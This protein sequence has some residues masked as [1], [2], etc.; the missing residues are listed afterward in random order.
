MNT[1]DLSRE[2]RMGD[3]QA[4]ENQRDETNPP[5]SL[6]ADGAPPLDLK[7]FMLDS[8]AGNDA[9]EAEREADDA[10]DEEGRT[11]LSLTKSMNY[12]VDRAV[13]LLADD[14]AVFQKHSQLVK[15]APEEG[16]RVLLRPFKTSQLRYILAKRAL[17]VNEKG[18]EVHPPTHIAKCILER[19]AWERIRRLRAVTDFPA[20]APDGALRLEP[21][22][23]ETT[24]TFFAGNVDVRVPEEPTRDDAR[25]AVDQLYDIVH[26]FPFAS[27]E[28]R[29][30]W[31][32]GLLTPLARY[33]H[34]GNAPL[35]VVQANGPRIGKTTLVKLISYVVTGQESAAMTHTTNEEEARKRILSLL[36]A[37]RTLVLVDNIV[38]QF[39]GATVNAVMTSRTFEDRLLGHSVVIR[40]TNDTTW[41]VTGNNMSLAPDTAERC[42][43]VRLQSDLEKPH[44]RTDF[45]HERLFDVVKERRGQLLSAALTIL[46]A[47]LVAGMPDQALSSWGGFESWS[48]V[49][50]GALVYAGASD[51]AATRLELEEHADEA[52]DERA[53]LVLGI[54]EWQIAAGR[55]AGW[56]ASELLEHV[57][58]HPEGAL[59]L[60]QAL[61]DI[62]GDRGALP[63]AKTLSRHLRESW[64]RNVRNIVLHREADRKNG[65]RWF[66]CNRPA[67]GVV[68]AVQPA[69]AQAPG[70]SSSIAFAG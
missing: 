9:E 15:V 22:Y 3:A 46:K 53:N 43:N 19:T 20:I 70:R 51:P 1:I 38:G 42:L 13:H 6:A 52:L 60:R 41:Y 55:V 57:R 32:A 49:V 27:D 24:Q 65:H 48:R 61:E 30:A 47:Y 66:V 21:G 33:A 34:D 31:L 29:A 63:N 54:A 2:G 14:E 59:R 23:D 67:D 26:D 44:L 28:H 39:G 16:D 68:T 37:G 58:A 62:A 5:S 56:K 35:V 45:R 40:A 64:R 7:S 36:H 8:L 69:A 18:K 11:V 12:L 10:V 17:W 50:R 25:A 4:P